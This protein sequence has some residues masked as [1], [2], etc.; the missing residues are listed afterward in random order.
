MRKILGVVLAFAACGD[1]AQQFVGTWVGNETVT[2]SGGNFGSAAST[3]ESDVEETFS[4]D[5]NTGD[6]DFS[7]CGWSGKPNG[8]QL[9]MIAN[10]T[11]CDLPQSNGCTVALDLSGGTITVSG[12]QETMDLLGNAAVGCPNEAIVT[13]SFEL[14]GNSTRQ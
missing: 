4:E 12:N 3:N 2:L 6:V 7:E 9:E 13:G 14:R 11:P 1:P 8:R 10:L 5:L